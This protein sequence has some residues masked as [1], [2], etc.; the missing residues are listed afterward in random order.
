MRLRSVVPSNSFSTSRRLVVAG[1]QRGER[2]AVLD[3]VGGE[4]GKAGSGTAVCPRILESLQ[5]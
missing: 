5:Q 1:N 2:I 4:E 3:A